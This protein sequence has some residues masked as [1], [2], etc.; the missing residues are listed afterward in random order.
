MLRNIGIID[1]IQNLMLITLRVLSSTLKLVMSS[2]NSP[3]LKPS[4]PSSYLP[5]YA[6]SYVPTLEP[7]FNPSDAPTVVPNL[8]PRY[9]ASVV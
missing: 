4:S 5:S 9:Y 1:I 2:R 8:G 7:S 6:L 3:S